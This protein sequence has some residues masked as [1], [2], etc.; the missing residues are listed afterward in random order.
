MERIIKYKSLNGKT[1]E[2]E[3]DC[4]FEEFNFEFGKLLSKIKSDKNKEINYLDLCKIGYLASLHLKDKK[5]RDEID[6]FKKE[7]FKKYK[8]ILTNDLFENIFNDM[9]K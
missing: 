1:F 7:V 5:D 4:L 8:N 9:F 3:K 6:F 2:N